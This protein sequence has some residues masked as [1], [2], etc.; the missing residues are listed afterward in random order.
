VGWWDRIENTQTLMFLFIQRYR[1]N[2]NSKFSPQCK[3]VNRNG[4]FM[5][6]NYESEQNYY[7]IDALLE[8][9]R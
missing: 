7:A 9:C 6:V 5:R 2:K 4:K 8:S 3:E 1:V